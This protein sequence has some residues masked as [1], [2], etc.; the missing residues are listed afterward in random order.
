MLS[1]I[2]GHLPALEAVLAEVDR[3]AVDRIVL[4][5]DIA[6]GPMPVPTLRRLLELGDPSP[7][8]A[9][10]ASRSGSTPSSATPTATMRHSP[11]PAPA[12]AAP[13]PDRTRRSPHLQ[14]PS[15]RG[16]RSGHACAF[17]CRCRTQCRQ[18]SVPTDALNTSSAAMPNQMPVK[19][20]PSGKARRYMSDKPTIQ[21]AT[22]PVRST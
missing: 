12:T 21:L 18:R 10:R 13:H 20:S 6:A 22:S 3:A 15:R 9:T 7:P 5:G 14:P 19:P 11:C 1:D 17:A 8:T 4:T 2:H 16:C